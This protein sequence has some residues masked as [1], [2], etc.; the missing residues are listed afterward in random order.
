MAENLNDDSHTA[1]S[2]A[3]YNNQLDSCA[4]YGRL[5]NWEAANDI[6]SKVAGWHLAS[7]DEWRTLR[8]SLGGDVATVNAKLR[9]GGSS[10]FESKLSGW[11]IPG[12]FVSIHIDGR[13]W[14]SSSWTASAS[15]HVYVSDISVF[16]ISGQQNTFLYSIRLLQDK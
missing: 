9:E 4:I 6:A 5:Y 10:R 8:T 7:Q 3:C 1:G 16:S 12:G 11:G 13:Y 14:T 15:W 2:S